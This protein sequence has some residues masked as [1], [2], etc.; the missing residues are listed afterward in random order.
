[1]KTIHLNDRELV[2]VR[3]AVHSW[4]TAFGHDESQI[5]EDAK[6]VL[7]KLDIAEDEPQSDSELIG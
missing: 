4:V 7:G 6:A 5:V 3:N 1:M 2:L